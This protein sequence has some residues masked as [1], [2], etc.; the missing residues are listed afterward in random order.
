MQTL[1]KYFS[2]PSLVIYSFATSGIQTETG[3]ANMWGITNSKPLGPIITMGPI[4]NTSDQQSDGIA[5]L[6]RHVP[7]TANY[8]IMLSQNPFS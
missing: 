2:H 5:A 6:L 4:R 7:A 8:A 3:T 1:Q